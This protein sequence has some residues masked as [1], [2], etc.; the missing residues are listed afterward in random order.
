MSN[1]YDKDGNLVNRVPVSMQNADGSNKYHGRDADILDWFE[2][3]PEDRERV[4][5]AVAEAAMSEAL[6]ME[7]EKPLHSVN[8]P[9]SAALVT[10]VATAA[11]V[12]EVVTETPAAEPA[13]EAAPAAPE[14][15][16]EA[17]AESTQA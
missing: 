13:V 10:E 8:D 3:H 12:A 4:G 5:E 6:V 2:S 7:G 16:V 14:A 15:A 1:V 17:P 11:A 9:F